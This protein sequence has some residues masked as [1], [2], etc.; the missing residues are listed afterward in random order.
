MGKT[1]LALNIAEYAAKFVD[2]LYVSLEMSDDQLTAKRISTLEG[3]DYQ[4]VLNG[5]LTEKQYAQVAN[6]V[7]TISES[8]LYT[9]SCIGANVRRICDM[10]RSRKGVRL[11][12]I[13]HFSLV[14]VSSKRSRYEEYTA[15]S[16][17]TQT[18]GAVDQW[19]VLCLAQLNRANEERKDKRPTMSDLRDTGAAEQDADGIFL[20]H[21]PGYYDDS[22][23][24]RLSSYH[25]I[26]RG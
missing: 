4:T 22:E 15:V 19:V 13:D 17:G 26:H 1:T 20:L 6:A 23:K 14:Q 8:R 11:V 9:N 12:I 10:T 3:I 5:S 25:G 21:R 24:D 7:S 18:F 16:A 2:V